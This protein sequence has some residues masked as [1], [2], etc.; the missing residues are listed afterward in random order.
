MTLK[1][2][3]ELLSGIVNMISKQFKKDVELLSGTEIPDTFII[4]DKVDSGCISVIINGILFK[5]KADNYPFLCPIITY[6]NG[7]GEK[8]R[9]NFLSDWNPV[10]NLVSLVYTLMLDYI[11]YINDGTMHIE[12]VSLLE[13]MKSQ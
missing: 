9:I 7:A 2:D 12:R 4:A 13:T 8:E 3:I 6:I 10:G 11:P 5:I 1:R